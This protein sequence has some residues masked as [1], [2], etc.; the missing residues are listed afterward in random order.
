MFTIPFS[1]IIP[2]SIIVF[3]NRPRGI[4][5]LVKQCNI[6]LN[7]W[8]GVLYMRVIIIRFVLNEILL[9]IDLLNQWHDV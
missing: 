9:H 7:Q 2:F 4:P 6:L 5:C 1:S 3:H 8:H